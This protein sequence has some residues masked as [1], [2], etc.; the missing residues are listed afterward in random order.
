MIFTSGGVRNR[1]PLSE[2]YLFRVCRPAGGNGGAFKRVLKVGSITPHHVGRAPRAF[3]FTAINITLELCSCAYQ[4]GA[5]AHCSLSTID[6]ALFRKG[7]L[8]SLYGL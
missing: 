2:N 3:M 4:Q 6:V 7:C 1:R 5:Y 8:T